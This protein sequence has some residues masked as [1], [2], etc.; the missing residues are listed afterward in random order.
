MPRAHC[1]FVLLS[2]SNQNRGTI[3]YY[4]PRLNFLG[5]FEASLWDLLSHFIWKCWSTRH[6]GDASYSL[7]NKTNWHV[8]FFK[9]KTYPNK[10]KQFKLRLYLLKKLQAGI[11]I[12]FVSAGLIQQHEE[13]CL[14]EDGGGGE[15]LC[16]AIRKEQKI[17]AARGL[18]KHQPD[19]NSICTLCQGTKLVHCTQNRPISI[20]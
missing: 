12:A 2:P 8:I 3:R 20:Y 1:I 16:G 10:D 19:L 15:E 9:L 18:E 11:E 4:C 7:S 6:F 14:V 17:R 5:V 13:F